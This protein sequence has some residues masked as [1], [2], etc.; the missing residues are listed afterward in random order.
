MSNRPFSEGLH[1]RVFVQLSLPQN[2]GL[3]WNIEL[4][5]PYD[6]MQIS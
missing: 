2:I 3:D 4:G 5:R 6:S 1:S